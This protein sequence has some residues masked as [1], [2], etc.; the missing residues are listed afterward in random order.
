M[1]RHEFSGGQAPASVIERE[2]RQNEALRIVNGISR[3]TG[4]ELSVTTS[5]DGSFGEA[6]GIYLLDP[7]IAARG[8]I[9][10]AK[11]QF[12]EKMLSGAADSAHAVIAGQLAVVHASGEISTTEIAAKCY[13]KRDFE[14]RMARASR[15]VE[16]MQDMARRGELALDPVA[17]AVTSSRMGDAVVL[18][19]RFN[20]DLYTLDN[21]P[22]GRGPTAANVSNATL[23]AQALGRFNAMGYMHRDAKIK[24]VASVAG[25]GVGMIDFETSDPFDVS[26]PIQT[27][28]AAYADLE[29]M[30]GSLADKGLFNVRRRRDF[31]DNS[32]QVLAA[33]QTICEDGY[34]S[35]WGEAS[36]DIQSRVYDMTLN[37]AEN[38]T[39]RALGSRVPV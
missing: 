37:V 18:L 23:A 6:P 34:L 20:D 24:N 2:Q 9:K 30:M 4:R 14:E 21:N 5:E 36:P 13:Q 31:Q 38:M 19:T 11:F 7:S 25:Q 3:A 8:P 33:V 26:D 10:D 16:V 32:G 27:G 17:V 1:K 39:Q 12:E 29:Y 28:T 35:A 15:E 22:W